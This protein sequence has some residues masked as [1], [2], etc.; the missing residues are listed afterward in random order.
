MHRETSST[1]RFETTQNLK[2]TKSF[3]LSSLNQTSV[4]YQCDRTTQP[5]SIA[6]KRRPQPWLLRKRILSKF[7]L[8]DRPEHIPSTRNISNDNDLARCQCGCDHS[9]STA[10]K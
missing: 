9:Q 1:Q 5:R 8:D 6:L 7:G 10:Q 3:S 4:H 2:W